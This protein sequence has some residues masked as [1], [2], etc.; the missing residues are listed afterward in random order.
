MDDARDLHADESASA[1]DTDDGWTFV[2][3]L[4]DLRSAWTHGRQVDDV[5][6]SERSEGSRIFGDEAPADAIVDGGIP[7][8]DHEY[9]KPA[10]SIRRLAPN[11]R[12][13]Y[14]GN[15]IGS[16]VSVHS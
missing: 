12:G 2:V 11:L 16:H 14:G 13:R 5:N 3:P 8:R 10:G 4:L 1:A 9:R 6:V 7:R 15:G